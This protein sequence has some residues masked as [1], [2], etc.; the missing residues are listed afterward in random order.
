MITDS[1]VVVVDLVVVVVV[2]GLVVVVW[3]LVVVGLGL[4]V[5]GGLPPPPL[6]VGLGLVGLGLVGL[7]LVEPNPPKFA[8]DG[9]VVPSVVTLLLFPT[10]PKSVP[11]M[12]PPPRGMMSEGLGLNPPCRPSRFSEIL[13]LICP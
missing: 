12:N 9:V 7:G 2:V 4:V 11:S 5:V 10:N 1:V 13:G 3:G 8:V 6:P